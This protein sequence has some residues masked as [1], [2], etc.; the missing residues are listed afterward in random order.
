[1]RD[2][3]IGEDYQLCDIITDGPLATMKKNVEGVDVPKTRADC[4]AEDLRKWEKNAKAK[5]WFVC[6]LGPDEYSRIPSCTTAKEI[7]DTLQVAHEGTPQVKRSIGTLIY[8]QY[9]NFTIEEGETIQEMYTRFTTLTNELKSFGRVILEEDRVE[10]ILTRLDELIGNLTAYELRRQTMKMDAPKK[11]RSM[12]FRITEGVDLEEDEMTM[13]TKVFKKYLM[14]GKGPSRSGSYNKPRIP[15]NKPMRGVTNEDSEDEAG[16]EQALMDIGESDD[17]QEGM[18]DPKA[19]CKNL[20][21]RDNESESENTE[22]KNQVLEL[23][24]SVLELKSENLKLKLGTG[25][26][27]ADHTHLTLEEN[28]GKMKDELYIKDEQ[29]RVLKEDIGKVKHELDELANGTRLL[30]H[31]PGYTNITVET[32]EDLVMEL[33]HLSGILKANEPGSSIDQKLYRGMIGS[34]LYLTTS[35]LDIVFN[36]GL[37]ARFQANSKESHLVSLWIGRAP[38]GEESGSSETEQVSSD[39]KI[40]PKTIS[41]IAANLENRFVGSIVGVET[42]K[43]GEVGGKNEKEKKKSKGARST[44]DEP[45]SS[46]EETL[47]RPAE[48]INVTPKKPSSSKKVPVNSKVRALVEESGAEDAEIERLKKRLV[49]METKRDALRT[50]LAREKEKNDGILQGVLKLLQVKNQA[51]SSSQP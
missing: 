17:E 35:K 16:D 29:I 47:A 9:E 19:K 1:M 22:L 36:V 11:E 39:S 50:E 41:K 13:I 46:V 31:S 44:G 49:E 18:Y 45:G 14:R 28:L 4:N 10:K 6:G 43:S 42:T 26:K 2:H 12:A 5:K 34:L 32:K 7:W 27:K 21:S 23:D 30:M 37:C 48:E 40:S 24:T 15:E 51:P 20:E 38:Q 8:S 3:I 25:K 33:K